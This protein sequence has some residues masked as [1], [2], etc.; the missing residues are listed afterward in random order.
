MR[1]NDL[2]SEIRNGRTRVVATVVWEDSDRPTHDLYFET[3]EEFASALS[4]NPHAFLVGCIVPAMHFGE[5]RV[6]IDAE[7]CR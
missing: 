1:I 7:I 2:R 3:E 6:A 5:K 4:L